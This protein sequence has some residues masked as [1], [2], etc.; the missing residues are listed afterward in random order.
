MRSSERADL[1]ADDHRSLVHVALISAQGAVKRFDR[2]V[3]RGIARAAVHQLLDAGG[4]CRRVAL[5]RECADFALPHQG[6]AQKLLAA[7]AEQDAPNLPHALAGEELGGHILHPLEVDNGARAVEEV[8][9]HPQPPDTGS[10]AYFY[11]QLDVEAG[12]VE[13][14]KAA[15]LRPGAA[16]AGRQAVKRGDDRGHQR[17]FAPLVAIDDELQP[18]RLEADFGASEH[19]EIGGE[20]RQAH[21]RVTAGSRQS[22]VGSRESVGATPELRSGIAG[23]PLQ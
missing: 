14:P 6:A 3:G 18:L 5:Q 7:E 2:G 8:A 15:A 9:P 19:A 1:A 11:V 10:C 12:T 20:A 16:V 21:G 4:E 17:G 22:G 23:F 13:R